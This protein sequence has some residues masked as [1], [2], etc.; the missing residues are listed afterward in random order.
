MVKG[1]EEGKQ[2]EREVQGWVAWSGPGGS[3]IEIKNAGEGTKF[4]EEREIPVSLGEGN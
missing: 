2:Q 3:K 4:K 1:I